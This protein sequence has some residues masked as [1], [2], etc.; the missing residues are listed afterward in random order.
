[1]K[2]ICLQLGLC[3]VDEIKSL[4]F[5]ILLYPLAKYTVSVKMTAQV[6]ILRENNQC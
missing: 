1:M 5:H 6:V 4:S 3:H 2:G